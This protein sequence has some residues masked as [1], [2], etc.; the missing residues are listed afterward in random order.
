LAFAG[1]IA[2]TI[3]ATVAMLAAVSSGE[4]AAV[5]IVQALAVAGAVA[6]VLYGAVAVVAVMVLSHVK[7]LV[8]AT[9]IA[10]LSAIVGILFGV[11]G[12]D[13]HLILAIAIA[14]LL[15]IVLLTLSLQAGWQSWH[16]DPRYQLIRRIALALST[17]GTDFRGADLTDANFS[18]AVLRHTNFKGS[19]LVRTDW[20]HAQ[21]LDRAS[22]ERTY[23]E[24]R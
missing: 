8:L 10:F 6:G 4:I 16:N 23:L 12:T 1:A 24:D 5:T 2:V 22:L 21:A 15:A 9:A 17:Q 11:P 20:F 3:A 7:V 18:E 14:V 19:R 13:E